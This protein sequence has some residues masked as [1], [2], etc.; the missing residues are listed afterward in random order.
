MEIRGLIWLDE[1][2]DKLA[3]NHNVGRTEVLETLSSGPRIRFVE[4]GHREGE[5]VYAA[6][7]RSA[8]GRYL[9]VFFVLKSGKQALVISARTMTAR[10]RKC[11]EKR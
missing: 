7:G 1:I 8:E 10:E 9:V 6:F 3:W 11:Y 4:K 5:N 2:V